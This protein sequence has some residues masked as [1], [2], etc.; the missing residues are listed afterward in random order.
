MR[1]AETREFFWEQRPSKSAQA[2]GVV[3]MR[4]DSGTLP[5]VLSAADTA[6]YMAKVRCGNRVHVYQES[7]ASFTADTAKC[8]GWQS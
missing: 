4:R 7:D 5:Q 3:A 8:S 6:C 1:R 2:W